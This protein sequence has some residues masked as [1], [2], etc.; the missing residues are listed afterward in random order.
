MGRVKVIDQ[1]QFP[2]QQLNANVRSKDLSGGDEPPAK[3]VS[4]S[5]RPVT[6]H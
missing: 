5:R 4:G 3:A 6:P 2:F 1:S